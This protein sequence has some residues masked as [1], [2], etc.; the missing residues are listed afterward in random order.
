MN[1]ETQKLLD[2]ITGLIQYLTV[3]QRELWTGY[4]DD[5]KA[6]VRCGRGICERDEEAKKELQERGGLFWKEIENLE[7]ALAVLRVTR[8][9]LQL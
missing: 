9:E 8:A 4:L 5:H 3:K 6:M 1:E 7:V 2:A